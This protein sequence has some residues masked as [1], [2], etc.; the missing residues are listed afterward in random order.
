MPSVEDSRTASGSRCAGVWIS[1]CSTLGIVYSDDD[2]CEGGDGDGRVE[3]AG[4]V[5]P[6]PSV[7]GWGC[8]GELGFSSG[9]AM[10]SPPRDCERLRSPFIVAGVVSYQVLNEGGWWL[11]SERGD[12]QACRARSGGCYAEGPVGSFAVEGPEAR[13]RKGIAVEEQEGDGP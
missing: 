5:R 10:R 1:G 12:R 3:A 11:R 2:A 8:I 9:L 6:S 13:S 4:A 7:S